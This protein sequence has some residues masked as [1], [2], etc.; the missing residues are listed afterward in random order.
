MQTR[1]Y[2]DC[3]SL[4]RKTFRAGIILVFGNLAVEHEKPLESEGK[5]PPRDSRTNK[6][7]IKFGCGTSIQQI[8]FPETETIQ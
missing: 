1:S 5:N 4:P 8:A 2:W 7:A 3:S 6:R